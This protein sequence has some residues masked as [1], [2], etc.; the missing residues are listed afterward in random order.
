MANGL[1]DIIKGFKNLALKVQTG[2]SNARQNLK[3]QDLMLK[4]CQKE[5]QKIY[6]EHENSKKYI[7]SLKNSLNNN[8]SNNNYNNVR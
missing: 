4:A 1:K 6:F 5:Y 8:S 2:N 7:S 3:D